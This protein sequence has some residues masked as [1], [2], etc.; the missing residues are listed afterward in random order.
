MCESCARCAGACREAAV[1]LLRH[2]KGSTL[3]S[4]RSL[5]KFAQMAGEGVHRHSGSTS[6]S[7]LDDSAGS[8]R[9]TLQKCDLLRGGRLRWHTRGR[10][11]RQTRAPRRPLDRHRVER[12]AR[13]SRGRP[14]LR[15]RCAR[16][17][18][19]RPS[20]RVFGRGLYSSGMQLRVVALRSLRHLTEGL[21]EVLDEVVGVLDADG[22]TNEPVADAGA[23]TLITREPRMRGDR[24]TRDQ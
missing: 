5:V 9:S 24:W 13:E 10:R 4:P 20:D 8:L 14:S 21:V 15:R 17:S 23:L 1:R 18:A 16:S 22:E 11:R 12:R 6:E 3:E 19:G 7:A 2:T